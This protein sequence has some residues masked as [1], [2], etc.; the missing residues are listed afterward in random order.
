MLLI[1]GMILLSCE[2]Q[3]T[4]NSVMDEIQKENT[5]TVWLAKNTNTAEVYVVAVSEDIV[6]RELKGMRIVPSDTVI[7]EEKYLIGE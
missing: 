3:L 7:I 1:T 2:N 5:S 6:Y 4:D